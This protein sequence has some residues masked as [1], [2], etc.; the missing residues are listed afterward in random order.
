MNPVF[1][2]GDDPIRQ[3]REQWMSGN[4][5][6]AF[7]PGKIIGYDCNA[8]TLLSLE[9]AG[10]SVRPAEV[11][12]NGSDRIDKYEKLAVSI[13]GT[14]L[15]RGGGGVRCMTMPVRRAHLDTMG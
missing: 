15:A 13:P 11:F 14:E 9:K 3:Q 10:Y 12:I 5:F 7:E 4:N 6:F 2:G 1:C 8:A